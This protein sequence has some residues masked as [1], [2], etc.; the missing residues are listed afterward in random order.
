MGHA[1]ETEVAA[2]A[3]KT[4]DRSLSAICKF[5]IPSLFGMALFLMPVTVDGNVTVI[6]G[7]YTSWMQSFFGEALLA[8]VVAITVISALLGSYYMLMK[9]DWEEKRPYLY[10]AATCTWGWLFLRLVGAAIGIMVLFEVGPEIVR[11]S[12]TGIALFNEVGVVFAIVMLPACYVMPLLTDFGAMEFFGTFVAPAFRRFFRLPGRSAV[13]AMASF[14]SANNVGVLV[15]AQQYSRNKYTAREAVTIATNFS[16]VSLPFA[17]VIAEVSGIGGEF[18]AWYL[19]AI[20]ACVVCAVI[21]SRLPPLSR[22]PDVHLDGT[23]PFRR[24]Q[25][26]VP[27][28]LRSIDNALEAAANVPPVRTQAATATRMVV[29]QLFGVLG[30][31]MGLATLTAIIA[32]HS[33]L[34]DWISMPIAF[35][36]EM[37]DI[38]QPSR[39]AAGIIFGYLDQ[40]IPAIIAGDITSQPVKFLLAG[41]SLCQ[42]VF[43]TETGLVI[44][45]SG[46]PVTV[47]QL[48]QV[49][50]LRTIIVVPVLTIGAMLVYG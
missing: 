27:I 4:P 43:M 15:T 30:P 32:F 3:D 48:T 44:L 49:F 12:D 1:A 5:L 36:L 8:G 16:V 41:L 31:V 50:I 22:L 33:P 2:G 17:L 25:S 39:V 6:F 13:D 11:L 29:E 24:P 46:L 9:P 10:A 38:E 14:V 37:L 28:F 45:R 26:D 40:F 47:F 18:F 7:L 34:A 23:A 20:V 19:T 35:G 42:L 21:T